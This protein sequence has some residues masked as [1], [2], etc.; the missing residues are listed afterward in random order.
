MY[1]SACV[2]M[3]VTVC[4][5]EFACLHRYLSLLQS[6]YLTF[7]VYHLFIKLNEARITHTHARTLHKERQKHNFLLLIVF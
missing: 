6:I 2:C 7:Y 3:C 4:V 5:R 1:S